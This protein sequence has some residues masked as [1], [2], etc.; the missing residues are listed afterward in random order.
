MAKLTHDDKMR[1]Q[2]LREQGMGYKA[3]KSAYPDKNWSIDTLKTICR[4]I[5]VTGSAVDRKKGSGR[6]KSARSINNIDKVQQLIYSQE[7]EPGTSRSTRQ[8]A[9]E[10]GISQR[11]VVRIAKHDLKLTSF[12]RMPVQV[13][14]DAT[15]SKRLARCRALLRRLTARK[16]KSVFFTDE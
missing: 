16:A 1:I 15:K 2:T 3:I 8:V 11:S 13:I 10:V 12:K 9:A 6:P 4:R 5:D 7:D 14:T